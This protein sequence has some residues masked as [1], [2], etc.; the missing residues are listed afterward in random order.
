MVA[1]WV[2][3]TSGPGF[4]GASCESTAPKIGSITSLAWQHGQI[5]F[6]FSPSLRPMAVFYS[7]FKL[8]EPWAT[9]PFRAIFAG[10]FSHL[11]NALPSLTNG[12]RGSC[13]MERLFGTRRAYFEPGEQ[14]I[15][16]ARRRPMIRAPIPEHEAERLEA[17]RRYQILDTGSD[18]VFDDLAALASYICGTPIALVILVDSDRQ[19]FKAKTTR[20]N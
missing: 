18:P 7:F 3:S 2:R 6:R 13:M 8:R 14:R 16:Y 1:A 20:L 4:T 5:T 15:C 11:L 10:A 9:V 12:R 19:W 17:L